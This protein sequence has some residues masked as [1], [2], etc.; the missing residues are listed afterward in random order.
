MDGAPRACRS[1][2][3]KNDALPKKE[4]RQNEARSSMLGPTA[5]K[6][7]RSAQSR[8]FFT[9]GRAGLAR[10][11]ALRQHTVAIFLADDCSF[12]PALEDR[13]GSLSTSSSSDSFSLMLF[14]STFFENVRPRSLKA[15]LQG[16]MRE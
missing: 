5:F 13:S 7:G 16:E 15:F 1:A 6:A 4:E 10:P 14:R 3:K 8:F 12:L 11:A 2:V 9:T